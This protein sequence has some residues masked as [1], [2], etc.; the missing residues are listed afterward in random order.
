MVCVFFAGFT[1][2]LGGS[3]ALV[4]CICDS[5]KSCTRKKAATIVCVAQWAL[6]IVFTLSF[7]SGWLSKIKLLGLG[8]FDFA[9]FIATLCMALGAIA[10]LAYVICRWKFKK[11][12][13]EANAGATGKVR[14]HNWMKVYIYYIF[15]VVLGFVFICLMQMYF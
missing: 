12:Q 6:S 3:E 7:G 5:K 4:A 8:L 10:M 9:D 13:Q 15:P 2:I 11:F 1:S 14:V